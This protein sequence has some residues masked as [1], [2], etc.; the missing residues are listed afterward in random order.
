L[1]TPT[2]LRLY[3]NDAWLYALDGDSRNA[4]RNMRDAFDFAP[5]DAWR[6]WVLAVHAAIAASFGESGSASVIVD[7]A[8]RIGRTVVWDSTKDEERFALL[9][10]AEAA[11]QVEAPIAGEVLQQYWDIAGAMDN[12][13]ALRDRQTDPRLMGWEAYVRGIVARQGG[14]SA[15]AVRALNE[16]V[17]A[18]HSCGYLW[19]EALALIELDAT[20]GARLAAGPSSLEQ[21]AAIVGEHF[22]QSFLARRFGPWATAF[23][24]ADVRALTPAQR[25]VLRH[26][27]DGHPAREIAAITGRA[28]QTVLSHI[29][30]IHGALGT[31]CVQQIVVECGR[32]GIGAPSWRTDT[33][34]KAVERVPFG[35][36]RRTA[37]A[38][39]ER[40]GMGLQ[41][42]AS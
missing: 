17:L 28:Y 27:L 3:C 22:P 16:A 6:V 26:L 37:A 29:K 20:P 18:F 8:W 30:A 35:R 1:P 34:T 2:R 24:D 9:Q 33:I 11:A 25:D 14:D 5:S 12:T 41:R 13:F 15:G 7:D 38:G 23:V 4:L 39:E 42:T 40:G 31:R 19:R 21:A 32:R 36:A 10:L